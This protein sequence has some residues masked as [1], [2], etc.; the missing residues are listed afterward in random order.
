[1]KW[2]QDWLSA[3]EMQVLTD[4]TGSSTKGSSRSSGCCRC[5]MCLRAVLCWRCA[6]LELQL[7]AVVGLAV[8]SQD[9]GHAGAAAVEQYG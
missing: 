7:Q 2:M 9:V 1:M 4:T 6:V 3:A 8:A 5:A